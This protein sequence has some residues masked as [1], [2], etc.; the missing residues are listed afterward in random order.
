MSSTHLISSH[1]NSTQLTQLHSTQLNSTQLNS[2]QL[3]STQ[4]TSTQLNSTQLNSTQLK[5][6][7]SK[8]ADESRR[9]KAAEHAA[10]ASTSSGEKKKDKTNFT[11]AK[12]NMRVSLLRKSASWG[13]LINNTDYENGD[14]GGHYGIRGTPQWMAPEVMEGQRY[15][16]KVDVYSY[17]IMLTE[18][19]TRKMPFAD[20]YD[21][22]DFIDGVLEEGAIPTIPSWL[23]PAANERISRAS[24]VLSASE[25]GIVSALGEVNQIVVDCLDRDPRVRP[26]FSDI[27]SALQKIAV[28]NEREVLQFMDI[29]RLVD[30]LDAA[31][32]ITKLWAVR[33]VGDM[34]RRLLY[35]CE[36]CACRDGHREELTYKDLTPYLNEIAGSLICILSHVPTP[37]V[38]MMKEVCHSVRFRPSFLV[39]DSMLWMMIESMHKKLVFLFQISVE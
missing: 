14:S 8:A 25:T 38:S 13:N 30:D 23:A 15:N 16:G 29:P 12:T 39:G 31:D 37:D 17:G 10:R 35:R 28:L 27:V 6:G 20:L 2:T 34:C 18:I 4:L 1:L 21:G 24:S 32:P 7:R 22:L 19:F 26:E 11:V 36:R 5:S 33:E 9:S 3:N